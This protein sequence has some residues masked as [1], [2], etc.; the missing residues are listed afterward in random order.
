MVHFDKSNL[1]F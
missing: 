1:N